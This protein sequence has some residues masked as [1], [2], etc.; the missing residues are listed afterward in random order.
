VLPIAERKS[1][2]CCRLRHAGTGLSAGGTVRRFSLDLLAVI[3]CDHIREG[4][5][6][7]TKFRRADRYITGER[8]SGLRSRSN[9]DRFCR[10]DGGLYSDLESARVVVRETL[11]YSCLFTVTASRP[12]SKYSP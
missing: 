9:G 1:T 4:I 7:Q 5:K 3:D 8:V 11:T 6:G 10:A 12:Y 2:V